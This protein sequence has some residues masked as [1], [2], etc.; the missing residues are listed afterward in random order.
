MSFVIVDPEALV[1]ASTDVAAV[2]S[3]I[4]SANALA[5]GTTTQMAAAGADE[6]SAVFAGA[7]EAYARV[8]SSAE[9]TGADLL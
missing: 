9:R 6:V 1:A 7:F 4:R 5:A 3:M 8:V 2:G